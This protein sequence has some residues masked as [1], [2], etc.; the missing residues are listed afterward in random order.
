MDK[1]KKYKVLGFLAVVMGF[2]IV[3]LNAISY[4]FNW[5]I[6]H[7]AFT[8]IGLVCVFIGLRTVSRTDKQAG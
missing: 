5:D 6:K 1:T 7:P 2:S 8:T 4:L 3:L